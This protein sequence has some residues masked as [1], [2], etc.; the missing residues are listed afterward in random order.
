[1]PRL[2][3]PS[4]DTDNSCRGIGLQFQSSGEVTAL[5]ESKGGG[6]GGLNPP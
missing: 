2:G 1:M 6:L 3:E 4:E 5:G